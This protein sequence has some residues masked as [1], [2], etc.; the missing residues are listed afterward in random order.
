MKRVDAALLKVE[1]EN[2]EI[3]FSA[4]PTIEMQTSCIRYKQL[5]AADPEWMDK[6]NIFED[7][8]FG[9]FRKF[10]KMP[11]GEEKIAQVE[12]GE[13]IRLSPSQCMVLN[14][15]L[16]V[17]EPDDVPPTARKMATVWSDE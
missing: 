9:I 16:F 14:G 17:S 13:Y 4:K 10:E 1:I 8:Y 7:P 6:G 2:G 5:R 11:N 12:R 3:R 15:Q